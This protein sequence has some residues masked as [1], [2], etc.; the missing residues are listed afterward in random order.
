MNSIHV[1]NLY[2]S[3]H[4]QQQS[5]LRAAAQSPELPALTEDESTLIKEKFSPE[6][7]LTLYNGQGNTQEARFERG[8]NIDTRI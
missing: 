6:K 2:Q 4:I 1:A 5:P 8:M 3:N 7:G